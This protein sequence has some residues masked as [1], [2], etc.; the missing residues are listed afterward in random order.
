[1]SNN[2]YLTIESNECL[3]IAIRLIKGYHAIT[4]ASFRMEPF[5]A[6]Y[7]FESYG[8]MRNLRTLIPTEII[9]DQSLKISH[10]RNNPFV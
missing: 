9:Q 7:F 2:K 6:N 3:N 8:G 1:L 10:P 4:G 5:G